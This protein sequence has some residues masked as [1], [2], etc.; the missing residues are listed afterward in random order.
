[1]TSTSSNA[2][3]EGFAQAAAPFLLGNGGLPYTIFTMLLV[4]RTEMDKGKVGYGLLRSYSGEVG[5]GLA[6]SHPRDVG[7]PAMRAGRRS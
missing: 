1:M 5:T 2:C 6:T 7:T 3:A 4:M